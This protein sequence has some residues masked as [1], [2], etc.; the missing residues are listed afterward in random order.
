MCLKAKHN[1]LWQHSKK[2]VVNF[3]DKCSMD[4]GIRFF[5]KHRLI[6]LE[7]RCHRRDEKMQPQ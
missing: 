5:I 4:P 1:M 2:T 6:R 3:S 7:L